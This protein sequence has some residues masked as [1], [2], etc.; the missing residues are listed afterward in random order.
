[1]NAV[2]T[3]Q[4]HRKL[5]LESHPTLLWLAEFAAA[6]STADFARGRAMFAPEAIGF[7]TIAERAV[8]LDTLVDSQ[9][10]PVWSTTRGFT[11]DLATVKHGGDHPVYWAAAQWTSMGRD[12]SGRDIERR[13]R[14]TIVLHDREGK[15]LA[16]HTHFSFVPSGVVTPLPMSAQ[17][18]SQPV[19][20]EAS[21]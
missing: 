5:S 12:A 4:D 21:A 13:G 16:M 19:V 2:P 20:P 14:A 7:G 8:G 10:R 11:F 3:L 6:V 18:A 1:M 9:W 15:L 17:A